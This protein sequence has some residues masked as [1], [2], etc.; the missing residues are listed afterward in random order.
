LLVCC[1]GLH[2]GQGL[3]RYSHSLLEK[4]SSV[5]HLPPLH[6]QFSLKAPKGT[7]KQS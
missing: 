5:N 4:K 1:T 3:P 7:P 6:Q 2:N